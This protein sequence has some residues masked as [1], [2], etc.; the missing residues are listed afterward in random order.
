MVAWTSD[1]H[2]PGMAS[3]R[4]NVRA[5]SRV[6][7]AA[8]GPIQYSMENDQQ[9]VRPRK[10]IDGVSRWLAP[11][12]NDPGSSTAGIGAVVFD[13]VVHEEATFTYASVGW[14]QVGSIGS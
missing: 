8:S 5:A 14:S 4:I 7:S 12:V 3:D 1:P 2:G 13:V 10:N 9:P 11:G 6:V